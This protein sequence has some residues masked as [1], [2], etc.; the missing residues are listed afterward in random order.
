MKDESLRIQYALKMLGVAVCLT[1][2]WL[3][4]DGT[5]FGART[6]GFATIVGIVGIGIIST[7][8]RKLRGR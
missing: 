5:L 3:M 8:A 1:G 2:A 7:S 6:T 4:F